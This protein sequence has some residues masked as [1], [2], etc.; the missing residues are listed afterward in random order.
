MQGT[1]NEGILIMNN[2]KEIEINYNTR[3][4]LNKNG[5]TIGSLLQFNSKE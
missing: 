2:G 4:L 5:E 3:S 1:L